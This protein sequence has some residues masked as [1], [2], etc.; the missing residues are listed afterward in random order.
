M[1][2]G[3]DGV[4]LAGGCSCRAGAF[5]M[6][7]EVGGRPLLSWGLEAMVAA[8][9]RVIVVAGAQAENVRRLVSGVAGAEL[10]VNE[11]WETG[12][13]SSVQA[14]VR[15]VRSARFFL[16]PGDMPLVRSEIFAA[17]LAHAEDVVIP[18]CAGR[19]GHPVLLASALIPGILAEPPGSSLGAFLRRRQCTVVETGDPGVLADLDFR[20]EFAKMDARLRAE[21]WRQ[22]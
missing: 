17:L 6:A 10:V 5:K 11:D 2:A 8:C 1:A 21:K 16:L 15:W 7:A 14:G 19:R 3:V 9:A 20:E 13:L 12:M 4:L 22:P 18:A